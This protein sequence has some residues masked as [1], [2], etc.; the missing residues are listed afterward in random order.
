ML[1][2]RQITC[3]AAH[4]PTLHLNLKNL[5]LISWWIPLV[6]VGCVEP[7]EPAPVETPSYMVVEGSISTLQM[8]YKVSLSRTKP[9]GMEYVSMESGATVHVESASGEKHYF[10]E[11]EGGGHY[12]SD[13]ECFVGKAGETYTLHIETAFGGKYES[14]PVLLRPA[15]PIDSLYYQRSIRS[16]PGG[17][18]IDGIQILL[19]AHDPGGAN[20]YLKYEWE[21]TY[22]IKVPYPES[23]SVWECYNTEYSSGILTANTR[24]LSQSRVIH[25]E[26]KH[27]ST[28]GF[29]LTSRYK[30]VVRQYSIS[31]EQF[32][33]WNELKKLSENQGTLFDPMPYDLT[34]N[35]FSTYNPDE[36]VIGLFSAGGAVEKEIYIDHADLLELDFAGMGCSARLVAVSGGSGGPEGYCL[37]SQGPYGSGINYYAP[38]ECCDCRLYGSLDKPGDWID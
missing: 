9:L 37:A 7:F 36:K 33:Y 34:G 25:M 12:Y 17:Q 22:R 8:P 35:V 32:K 6:L 19:D 5:R 21:E 27:V 30:L 24:L 13:P 31:E 10:D 29:K 3:T 23:I 11:S 2:L 18:A 15:P 14:T 20:H 16:S 1:N 4:M 28:A 26:M 38:E